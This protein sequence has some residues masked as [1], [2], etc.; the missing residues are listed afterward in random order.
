MTMNTIR[1]HWPLP[2]ELR[3]FLTVLTLTIL[4]SKT[5]Q[6]G[7][8]IAITVPA[9]ALTRECPVAAM[10]VW[11]AESGLTEGAVFRRL[12]RGSVG[13]SGSPI[14]QHRGQAH[15]TMRAGCWP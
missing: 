11:L 10:K 5:D 12:R 15:L 3:V 6:A 1:E 2:E 4:F 13:G 8:G 9:I 14:R 7:D